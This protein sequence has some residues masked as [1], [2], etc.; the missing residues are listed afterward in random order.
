MWRSKISRKEHQ[1]LS[2]H[3]DID[4]VFLRM[5]F[6]KRKEVMCLGPHKQHQNSG[7]LKAVNSCSVASTENM[8]KKK[9][10]SGNVSLE[11]WIFML[12]T[13][14]YHN[15]QSSNNQKNDQRERTNTMNMQVLR[16]TYNRLILIKLASI[17]W[18]IKIINTCTFTN[19]SR[20]TV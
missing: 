8:W 17:I 10:S 19:S 3:L 2:A 9:L 4:V 16:F 6:Y 11:V 15:D 7:M 1:R 13:L 5:Y 20:V 18:L 14:K 12:V